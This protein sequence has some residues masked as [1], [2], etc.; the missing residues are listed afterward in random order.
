MKI[1]INSHIDSM[2]A[3]N[4]LLESMKLYTEFKNYDILIF[5]T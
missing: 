1:L 5:I 3:L 4:Y 2:I